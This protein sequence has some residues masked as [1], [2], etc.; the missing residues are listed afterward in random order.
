MKDRRGPLP[1]LHPLSTGSR[2]PSW[3]G[4]LDCFR[5]PSVRSPQ[6]STALR[7][8]GGAHALEPGHGRSR[9]RRIE[10][11]EKEQGLAWLLLMGN[12]LAGTPWPATGQSN[13]RIRFEGLRK[14]KKGPVARDQF[15]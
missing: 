11:E 10:R 1:A 14:M 8:P 2:A 5:V 15:D 7:R 3:F 4:S 12:S 6:T 9:A 13:S